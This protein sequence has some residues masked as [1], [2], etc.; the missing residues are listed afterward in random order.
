MDQLQVFVNNKLGEIRTIVRGENPWFVAKD[1]ADILGYSETAMM[2]RR[3][4]G[5]QKTNLPLRQVGSNMQTNITIISEPG[6]YNA[7]FG[8]QKEEAKEFCTWVYTEVLPQIRKT[9]SFSFYAQGLVIEELRREQIELKE[10]VVR[11]LELEVKIPELEEKTAK[12][13]KLEKRLQNLS[14]RLSTKL[15]NKDHEVLSSHN[16]TEI[17]KKELGAMLVAIYDVYRNRHW[18]IADLIK[19][20]NDLIFEAI[21][22]VAGQGHGEDLSINSRVLGRWIRKNANTFYEKLKFRLVSKKHKVNYWKVIKKS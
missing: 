11:I 18:K 15:F 14:A 22:H 16:L 7:I 8:S 1:V 3:L 9:G 2:T 12:I 20:K 5:D 17:E 6:L 10:K 13:I 4:D 19:T 21:E